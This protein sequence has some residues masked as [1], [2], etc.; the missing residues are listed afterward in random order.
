MLVTGLLFYNVLILS[1]TTHLSL[2][3]LEMRSIHQ[4]YITQN[5]GRLQLKNHF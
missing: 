1:L 3:E 2:N 4:V 5:F